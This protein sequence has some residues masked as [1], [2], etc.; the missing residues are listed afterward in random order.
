MTEVWP[1]ILHGYFG[2]TR[3]NGIRGAFYELRELM[4][5]TLRARASGARGC[6]PPL[7]VNLR[8]VSA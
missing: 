2:S 5:N 1:F 8:A 7:N 4:N 3:V 6:V